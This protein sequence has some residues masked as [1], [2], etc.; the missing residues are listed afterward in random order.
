[1]Q[2]F[3][4]VEI[5]EGSLTSKW[6]RILKDEVPIHEKMANGVDFRVSVL[7]Y[8]LPAPEDNEMCISPLFF[9]IDVKGKPGKALEDT[10]K[11]LEYLRNDLRIEEPYPQ[12]WFSGQ[13]GFHVLVHE[14]VL[15]IEAH[16]SLQEILKSAVDQ[17]V[18]VLG[19]KSIDKQIYSRRR[20][21]RYENTRH[22][23]TGLYKIELSFDEVMSLTIDQIMDLAKSPRRLQ[24]LV[25]LDQYVP[26]DYAK[27]WWSS[28]VQDWNNRKQL[29]QLK[30]KAKL[31]RI[32]NNEEPMC[33]RFFMENGAPDGQRNK[34]TYVLASYF[35]NQG[36]PKE[37]TESMMIEW[38]KR[39]YGREGHRLGERVTNAQN[40]VRAVYDS[41]YYFSCATCK[42]IDPNSF[43]CPGYEACKHV[44]SEESQNP[45]KIPVVELS[46]ATN[47]IWLFK[48][49]K[50]PVHVIGAEGDVFSVPK[51]IRAFCENKPD[52]CQ[53]ECTHCSLFHVPDIMHV[54][55]M[56]S[57]HVL[58]M[59]NVND[60]LK[61]DAIKDMLKISKKCMLARIL[62]LQ[63]GNI[64]QLILAPMVARVSQKKDDTSKSSHFVNRT[65]YYI[66]HLTKS[67]EKYILTC[68]PTPDPNTQKEVF[69]IDSIEPARSSI[70]SFSPTRDDLE[71]LKIFKPRP[72][73]SLDSKFEE[74]HEDFEVNL[75]N[76]VERKIIGYGVDLAY[77]SVL[78]FS[79]GGRRLDKGWME[80]VILGDSAQGKT[81]VIRA[82]Y[83][84]Y[85]LGGWISGET[86][87][88]TGIS[89]AAVQANGKKGQ[90]ICQ[91]GALAQNDR[92]LLV[93]DEFSGMDREQ[94]AMLTSARSD[95]VIRAAGVLQGHEAYCRTR[96]IYSS[97][98]RP[99][100]NKKDG[101]MKEF[102][103]G[104]EAFEE[105]Y[106]EHQ[107]VRRV[108]F[109]IC[110]RGDEISEVA[111]NMPI[112]RK[113]PHV[114]T[115]ALCNRLLLW[116]WTRKPEHVIF[117]EDATMEVRNAAIRMCGVY[118]ISA[119]SWLVERATQKE[120]IARAAVSVA[121][122]TFS[123][124]ETMQRVIVKKEH[125][126][127][128]ER[129]FYMSYNSPGMQYNLFAA[130]NKSAPY[131]DE[132]TK[133]HIERVLDS[134]RRA[135][136][137]IKNLL[138]NICNAS[139]ITQDRLV[140]WGIEQNEAS[141]VMDE[142]RE[143]SL[144]DAD[145]MK[146]NSGIE[147]F[148][149]LN[150]KINRPVT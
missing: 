80:V 22:P 40:V 48:T 92:G 109:A 61:Y 55:S 94:F 76:I 100:G 60:A 115:S 57:R 64:S 21:M 145:D 28:I 54:V 73:Q 129:L 88:R 139:I 122:R 37:H 3:P 111:L 23:D 136:C 71:M 113:V 38:T 30:P 52:E 7:R 90:W 149:F 41:D 26:S 101:S 119:S 97:N 59:F 93:V 35:L 77:H 137:S 14:E 25:P 39:H 112:T 45:E 31:K 2:N 131:I 142:F 75:H 85:Q 81:A 135:R 110:L 63:P 16:T 124:D 19:I 13:K 118:A 108:D 27:H 65:G 114:Y 121:A 11:V 134:S 91:W 34:T 82:L 96:S 44:E 12:I 95:G 15:G 106:L 5:Q 123:T 98:P 69:L 150:D 42:S 66:G 17:V 18:G 10:R 36:V 6:K 74:I 126:L 20:I 102:M 140:K 89:Y 49:I 104:I 87:K 116:V 127:F 78:N 4:Y 105:L 125:V 130:H 58:R 147:F 50:M 33:V 138:K 120:K 43:Y 67:N 128:A 72:G 79:F 148:K 70:D 32:E 133:R 24:R 84:H 143:Q 47:A 83:D 141:K 68:T 144:I 107:D 53:G 46:E 1:M 132:S 8:K 9:D 117:E 99:R 51:T 103:Y 86:E 62:T 146:T 29:E 56:K